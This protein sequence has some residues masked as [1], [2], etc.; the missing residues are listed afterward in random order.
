MVKQPEKYGRR[1]ENRQ[2]EPVVIKE[3][4]RPQP[5]S[6]KPPLLP[7]GQSGT[8]PP[9]NPGVSESTASDGTFSTDNK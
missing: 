8:A 2:V 5:P 3:G 6:D 1:G 4:V 7:Q 9:T